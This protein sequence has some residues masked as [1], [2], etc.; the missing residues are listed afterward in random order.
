LAC[1][2]YACTNNIV[3]IAEQADLTAALTASLFSIDNDTDPF[4]DKASANFA[5]TTTSPAKATGYPGAY[6]DPSGTDVMIGYGDIGAVQLQASSASGT[7]VQNKTQ[8]N[9]PDIRVW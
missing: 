1:D 9:L 4:V 3:G 5:L 8:R 7:V 6:D 2:F